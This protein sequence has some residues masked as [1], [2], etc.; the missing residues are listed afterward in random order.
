MKKYI[1]LLLVLPSL[2]FAQSNSNTSLLSL[3]NQIDLNSSYYPHP[4]IFNEVAEKKK[5][6]LAIIYSLILPGMGE[7]YADGYDSGMYFTIAEGVLWGTLTGFNIYANQ[8]KDNYKAFAAASGGVSLEG[9]DDV[10]FAT[11]GEY[12]DIDQFNR[13]MELNRDFGEVYSTDT[14]YWKWDDNTERREYRNMWTSSENA[15]N[16]IRF[17]VGAMIL[18]RLISAINAVRLVVAYNKN[19]EK[20]VSWNVSMNIINHY[21]ETGLSLNLKSTF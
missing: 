6:G 2:I 7:M 16:N 3:K 12:L 15:F 20:E 11:I 9:K 5:P 19:L 21:N 4:Q 1:L 18:N 13:D 14:H 17:I 8:Q 10:F